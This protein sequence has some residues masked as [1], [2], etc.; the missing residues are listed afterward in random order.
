MVEPD[1]PSAALRAKVEGQVEVEIT[2]DERGIPVAFRIL[3]G[4]PLFHAAV[5][6]VLPDWRFDRVLKEGRPVRAIYRMAI[7]FTI[8]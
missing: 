1:Y 8:R 3:S 7:R 5:L 2:A 4:N 6:K